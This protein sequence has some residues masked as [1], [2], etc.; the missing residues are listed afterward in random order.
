M[1]PG[2]DLVFLEEL[3]GDLPEEL[4]RFQETGAILA[5]QLEIPILGDLLGEGE[6]LLLGAGAALRAL[7]FF[8]IPCFSLR[9]GCGD[10]QPPLP[11]YDHRPISGVI[12][13]RLLLW[14]RARSS[15]WLFRKFAVQYLSIKWAWTNMY[16]I[17]R[18][19]GAALMSGREAL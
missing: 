1:A 9:S 8:L 3:F 16:R 6:T 12:H 15:S 17:A 4:F 14:M 13:A 18:Q 19:T 7:G 2:D 5:A 10:T 11:N